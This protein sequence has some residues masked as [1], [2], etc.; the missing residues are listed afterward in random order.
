MAHQLR[1][2]WKAVKKT[3]A[4]K[5]ID[6]PQIGKLTRAKLYFRNRK[7]ISEVFDSLDTA[8][9]NGDSKTAGK[10]FKELKGKVDAFIK[11]AEDV[12]SEL[13]TGD[14]YTTLGKAINQIK[15]LV[16]VCRADVAE[17]KDGAGETGKIDAKKLDAWEKK[18]DEMNELIVE[19][20]G[21]LGNVGVTVDGLTN[22]FNR[23]IGKQKDLEKLIAKNDPGAQAEFD[24]LER[25]YDIR[26]K[27]LEGR[28]SDFAKAQA[29][30]G[31]LLPAMEKYINRP[32]METLAEGKVYPE[33]MKTL[34]NTPNEVKMVEKDLGKL[35]TLAGRV[36][37]N[38]SGLR[39]QMKDMSV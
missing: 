37:V 8:L 25:N 3:L 17:L 6:T 23:V 36:M 1:A 7:A 14:G 2:Q 18:L 13:K 34:K 12:R 30:L 4:D 15:G 35:E 9:D 24:K 20:I 39:K 16:M 19:Q 28:S 33:A 38:F 29:Q 26:A 22:E 32:G 31:K 10:L 11:A 27:E 21:I 5:N